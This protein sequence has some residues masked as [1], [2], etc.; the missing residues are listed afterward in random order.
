[1]MDDKQRRRVRKGAH[2]MFFHMFGK[3]FVAQVQERKGE[4][5]ALK[6]KLGNEHAIYMEDI[7]G[8]VKREHV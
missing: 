4:R 7:I 3:I 1:M 8:I 2:V 5:V 6:D